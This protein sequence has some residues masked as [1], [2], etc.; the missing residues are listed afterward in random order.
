MDLGVKVAPRANLKRGMA[1]HLERH[2][3]FR[4]AHFLASKP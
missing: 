2:A 3:L 1:E 4:R